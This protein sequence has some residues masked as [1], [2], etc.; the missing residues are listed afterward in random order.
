M[1]PKDAL[2][3]R[4]RIWPGS[5]KVLYISKDDYSWSLAAMRWR[6]DPDDDYNDPN[7]WRDAIGIRW[8]GVTADPDDKGNPRSHNQGMWFILPDAMAALAQGLVSALAL[9]HGEAATV[10]PVGR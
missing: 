8:N 9:V 7:S 3:P 1:H 5:L 6:D 10:E 2:S 4:D